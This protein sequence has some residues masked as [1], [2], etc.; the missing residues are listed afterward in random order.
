MERTEAIGMVGELTFSVSAIDK[1]FTILWPEGVK[2][3]D[4]VVEKDGK[5]TRVQIKTTS[6][7]SEKRRYC[8]NITGAHKNADVFVLHI[9]GTD[10]FFMLHAS[11]EQLKSSKY[12]V[13]LNDINNKNLNN[14]DI[15]I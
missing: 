7:I 10:I 3:Y 4:C 5:Y 8:W 1:G 15:F 2:G 9:K 6:V 13:G 11:D 14:W 12:R